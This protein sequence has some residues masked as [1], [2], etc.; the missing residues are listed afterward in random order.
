MTRGDF[1]KNIKIK[2]IQARQKTA[3]KTADDFFKKDA[4]QPE[5][6]ETFPKPYRPRR[7]YKIVR[8]FFVGFFI[9]IIGGLGGI[10]ADRFLFPYLSNHPLLSRYE[11]LKKTS[12]GTTIINQTKEIKMSEEEILLQ[13]I[14]KIL[15]TKVSVISETA[16]SPGFIFSSDGVILTEQK[17]ISSAE[18]GTSKSEKERKEI[19][20][21]TKTQSNETFQGKLIEKESFLGLALLKIEASN[22]PVIPLGNSDNLEVGQK[23]GV[24]GKETTSVMVSRIDQ[25]EEISESEKSGTSE[26]KKKNAL[27]KIDRKLGAEFN[28]SVLINLKGEVVGIYLAN[29]EEGEL[30]NFVIPIN[31]VKEFLNG[32]LPL[33]NSSLS[34]WQIFA[35]KE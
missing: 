3:S 7:F 32:E 31:E 12:N 27:I 34:I 24:V 6:S 30:V 10:L 21:T 33:N 35:K 8:L 29:E 1:M 11:F 13:A 15:P 25:I 2:S 14:K 20:L 4:N 26:D 22:L 23:L 9:L 16:E 18:N 19:S 5:A 17:I 28:G